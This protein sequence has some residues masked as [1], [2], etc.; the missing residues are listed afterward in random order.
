MGTYARGSARMSF[1]DDANTF[2]TLR[3]NRTN[4]CTSHNTDYENK[5]CYLSFD[6]NI[7]KSRIG[8]VA[9]SVSCNL[10]SR[11]CKTV[12]IQV[13][14]NNIEDN[15]SRNTTP[16]STSIITQMI[17][18]DPFGDFEFTPPQIDQYDIQLH[19][20]NNPNP[21]SKN[22]VVISYSEWIAEIALNKSPK[23][24][25]STTGC[26]IGACAAACIGGA[27]LFK[28]AL[29]NNTT[30]PISSDYFDLLMNT[31]IR[32]PLPEYPSPNAMNINLGNLLL[33]GAGSV[34]SAAVFFMDLLDIG[35]QIKIVDQDIVKIENMNRS[36]IFGKKDYHK[37]KAETCKLHVKNRNLS[38]T[39]FKG[40][41]D[42][43]Y[44]TEK[45]L[46]F[47]IWL[48]LA[49]ENGVRQ[50]IQNLFPPLMIHASTG[51]NWIVNFGRHIPLRDDCLLDRFPP[52]VIGDE[53]FA[54]SSGPVSLSSKDDAALPFASFFA[55]LLIA[56]DLM[57]LTLPR[58]PQ[59][60]NFALYDFY[61]DLSIVQQ[62]NKR[63][64]KTCL[65]QQPYSRGIYQKWRQNT[66][67][68]YFS[69]NA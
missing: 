60:T 45:A 7:Y 22:L 50:T 68:W 3:N 58:Y 8:Q 31:R 36:P 26:C 37:G 66:K 43:Y 46:G 28:F 6:D 29:D 19:I 56:I 41:W 69:I 13:V 53:V 54:C 51:R 27:Q 24:L 33:V 49:N 52:D 62:W 55:G 48:P 57:R 21:V 11:W 1:P 30:P 20:G 61:S 4:Q 18:A 9:I 42:D 47:D 39:Y 17:D 63:P 12:H 25:P 15:I 10:L 64:S 5:K 35:G 59:T 65:C 44:A 34:G 2:Y 67:Y 38:A 40:S 32:N 14:P 23:L 16:F